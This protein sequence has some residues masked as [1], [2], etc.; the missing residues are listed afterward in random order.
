MPFRSDGLGLDGFKSTVDR[1]DRRRLRKHTHAR[2]E[3]ETKNEWQDLLGEHHDAS[4]YQ[5]NERQEETIIR[6]RRGRMRPVHTTSTKEKAR[7]PG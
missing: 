5:S 2:K 3:R 4:H 1:F 7:R 6:V